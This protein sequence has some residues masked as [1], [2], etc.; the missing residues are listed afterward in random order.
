MCVESQ[1]KKKKR[2]NEKIQIINTQ[3]PSTLGLR[4]VDDD[5]LRLSC[6]SSSSK[7]TVDEQARGGRV[8]GRASG[9]VGESDARAPDGGDGEKLNLGAGVTI[10]LR[11]GDLDI[12]LPAITA[13][14]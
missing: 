13:G 4:I 5:D 14:S 8:E 9:L 2:T 6:L 1:K 11:L 10:P 3:N 12:C 7:V